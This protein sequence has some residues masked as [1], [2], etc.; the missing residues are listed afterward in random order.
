M[1]KGN[2][3]VIRTSDKAVIAEGV[4]TIKSCQKLINQ[5]AQSNGSGEYIIA[6]EKLKVSVKATAKGEPVMAKES[7]QETSAMA[8]TETKPNKTARYFK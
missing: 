7:V 5:D 4:P 2:L 8:E 3:H 1:P 6:S